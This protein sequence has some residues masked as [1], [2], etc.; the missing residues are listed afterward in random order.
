MGGGVCAPGHFHPAPLFK[1]TG[2][3]A[4]ATAGELRRSGMRQTSGKLDW[5]LKLRK[6][7]TSGQRTANPPCLRLLRQRPQRCDPTLVGPNRSQSEP[8]LAARAS[9][10]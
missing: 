7:V 8:R 9:L 10:S 1:G 6:S 4:I 3:L 2:A 5:E